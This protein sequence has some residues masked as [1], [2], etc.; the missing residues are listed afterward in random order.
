MPNKSAV[1]RWQAIKRLHKTGEV[2]PVSVVIPTAL[3]VQP[4]WTETLTERDRHH[5]RSIKQ[6]GRKKGTPIH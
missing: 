2:S 4:G 5:S 1:Q 6:C 3:R